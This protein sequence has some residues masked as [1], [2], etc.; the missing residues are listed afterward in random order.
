MKKY[1]SILICIILNIF[2]HSNAFAHTD[3]KITSNGQVVDTFAGVNAIYATLSSHSNVDSDTTYSCAAFLKKF[4]STL[5]G[6][7]IYN[8]N[9]VNAAPTV[10][11]SGH[12]VYLK[13]VSSPRPGDI[14]QSKDYSHVA[15]VKS[16]SG[17]NVTLIE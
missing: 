3:I 16:V 5:W 11:K 9:T 14:M 15:V 6:V 1:L 12:S 4:C 2:I 10:S 17:S 8:I 13:S 7:T